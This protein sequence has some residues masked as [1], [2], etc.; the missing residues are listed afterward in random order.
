MNYA[1]PPIDFTS[2]EFW[3]RNY[4]SLYPSIIS[5]YDTVPPLEYTQADAQIEPDEP[6]PLG[7]KYHV[8]K[9]NACLRKRAVSHKKK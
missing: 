2:E 5:I 4:E 9:R 8:A 7:E 6:V 3:T 1:A